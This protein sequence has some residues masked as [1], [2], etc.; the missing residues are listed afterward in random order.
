MQDRIYIVCY[1]NSKVPV[2]EDWGSR[3]L[4]AAD[5]AAR[6]SNNSQLNQGVLFGPVSGLIDL[7]CDSE[8]ATD[9]YRELIGD[10]RAHVGK[11]NVDAIIFSNTMSGW[12]ICPAL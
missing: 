5:I 12:R 10:T 11:R 1:P 3:P 7:E 6:R 2:G 8:E 4:S 9:T